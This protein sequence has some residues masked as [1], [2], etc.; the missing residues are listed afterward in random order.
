MSFRTV[1]AAAV[2]LLPVAVP[3]QQPNDSAHTARIRELTPT[4]PNWKFITELA[5]HPPA[6]G[7]VPTPLEVLGYA[8]GGIYRAQLVKPESPIAHGYERITLFRCTSIR[9]R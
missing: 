7:T 2:L 8:R 6:S 3:A 5:D 9:R 1:L 4:D